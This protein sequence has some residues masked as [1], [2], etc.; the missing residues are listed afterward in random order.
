MFVCNQIVCKSQSGIESQGGVCA[1]DA[2]LPRLKED[3]PDAGEGRALLAISL[4]STMEITSFTALS[5]MALLPI[6]IVCQSFKFH[7]V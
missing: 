7:Y 1:A 6:I 2:A 3:M 4:L 5:R